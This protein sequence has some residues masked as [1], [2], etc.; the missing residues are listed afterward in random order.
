MDTKIIIFIIILTSL[1]F[2]TGIFTDL[3]FTDEIAHFWQA[4]EWFISDAR[5]V[6]NKLVDSV[7]EHNHYR[8][9]VNGPLWQ[10]GFVVIWRILGTVSKNA[11]QLYQAIFYFLLLIFTYLLTSN[12]YN[13][14]L[15]IYAI[16]ILGT[17][18]LFIAFSVLLLEEVPI[19]MLTV[20]CLWLLLKKRLFYSAVVMGLMFLTKRNAYFLFPAFIILFFGWKMIYDAPLK[21][22]FFNLFLFCLVVFMITFL[23]FNW[24]LNNVNGIL[25][26]GDGGRIFGI[27]SKQTKQLAV[28]IID[29]ASEK[30]KILSLSR[31]IKPKAHYINYLPETMT[32]L[33]N[34]PKYLGMMF[35]FLLIFY[36]FKIKVN[37]EQQ[38]LILLVPILIYISL[39]LVSFK[40]WLGYRYIAPI[41]PFAAILSA[42]ALSRFAKKYLVLIVLVCC[43]QF[44]FTLLYVAKERKISYSEKQE[45]EFIKKEI[46]AD[47]KIL[48]PEPLFVSYYSGRPSIWV[49][50]FLFNQSSLL[51]IFNSD[52]AFQILKNM[53]IRYILINKIRIYDDSKFMHSGGWPKSFVEKLPKL[54]FVPLVF[55]NKEISIWKIR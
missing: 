19:T 42:K 20:I 23:D 17:I 32:S 40:G 50:A 36:L 41:L 21:I 54:A 39:M 53:Q 26:P 29:S 46:S 11:A 35:P 18:P 16:I 28:P 6:Y 49:N 30:N 44:L 13:K 51:D 45:I 14:K 27:I 47:S 1:I 5:P 52:N 55:D 34:L 4:Q 25:L 12:L 15:A 43:F 2:A 9:Y 24:R 8:Y 22:R 10:Y 38:D 48:T 3:K 7:P 37:F 33:P 31:Q